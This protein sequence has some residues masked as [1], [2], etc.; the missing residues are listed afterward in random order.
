MKDF[1][2]ILKTDSDNST[3]LM[4]LRD[5]VSMIETQKCPTCGSLVGMVA[6]GPLNALICEHC[7]AAYGFTVGW[8]GPGGAR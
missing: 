7:K 1:D 5:I 3:L 6:D 2:Y 8:S 4:V